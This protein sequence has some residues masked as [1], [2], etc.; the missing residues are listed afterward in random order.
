MVSL[1]LQKRLAA[2]VLNCGRHKVWLDPNE[3]AHLKNCTTRKSIRKLAKDGYIIR[4]PVKSVSR[5]RA[6]AHNLA[7]RKGRHMGIGKRRGT[8]NARSNF[9][10]QWITRLRVLR[11]L[12]HKYRASKKIDKHVYHELYLKAKGNAF[13]NKR[14]LVEH[15]HRQKS[16]LAREKLLGEQAAARRQKN[17]SKRQ[18][19]AA[20][21]QKR[22]ES[23][24][25]PKSKK[26]RLDATQAAKAAAAA[27]L[28]AG[29]GGKKAEAAA[30]AAAPAKKDAAPTKKEAAAPA[31]K[32]AA[33]APKK[34]EAKKEVAAAA[35][36]KEEA[37][38]DAGK[39]ADAKP[40]AKKPAPKK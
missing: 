22:T 6:R 29:K 1:K 4:K 16:E 11:R 23:A 3:T 40:A 31:K 36:K 9:K 35:P 14:V 12:L 10:T 20:K 13:K 21:V 7:K 19:I 34:A 26:A 27:A 39:K 15:I 30:A 5:A 17:K 33:A 8:K 25:D 2:S 32:E 28:K 38:K 18:R 37:K 24:N